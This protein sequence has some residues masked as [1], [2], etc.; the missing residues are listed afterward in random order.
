MLLWASLYYYT[1]VVVYWR[2]IIY[3]KI[4]IAQRDG[5]CQIHG[6]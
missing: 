6:F 2:Y 4:V 3:Y 5:F 1:D